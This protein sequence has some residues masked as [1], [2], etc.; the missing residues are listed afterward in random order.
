MK[1]IG[2][3]AFWKK[4]LTGVAMFTLLSVM[5]GGPIVDYGRA[6]WLAYR[7]PR[8]ELFGP[9]TYNIRMQSYFESNEK[10]Q[11]DVYV[12][13]KGPEGFI[14]TSGNVK[15]GVDNITEQQIVLVGPHSEVLARHTIA[16]EKTFVQSRLSKKDGYAIVEISR[17]IPGK[18]NE[19]ALERYMVMPGEIR[20]LPESTIDRKSFGGESFDMRRAIR[21]WRYIQAKKRRAHLQQH[22]GEFR[23]PFRRHSE[24]T[25][26]DDQQDRPGSESDAPRQPLST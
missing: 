5:Y 4:F 10:T 13:T 24:P 12:L 8:A 17:I 22:D 18:L 23:R 1:S 19:L 11:V 9:A 16:A 20:E 6:Q 14:D 15:L 7:L 2:S 3:S 21:R 26:D 25:R